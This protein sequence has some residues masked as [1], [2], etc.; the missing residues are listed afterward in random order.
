MTGSHLESAKA[1][2]DGAADWAAID[3]VSW[4]G[5]IGTPELANR[6]RGFAETRRTPGLPLITSG[7]RDPRP[8]ADAV[9]SAL[10]QF[11]ARTSNMLGILSLVQIPKE[12]YLSLP[13]PPASQG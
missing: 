7:Q 1:V 8:I 12:D 9:S 4:R 2:A 3:A 6:L 10:R 13:I 5:M 11:D